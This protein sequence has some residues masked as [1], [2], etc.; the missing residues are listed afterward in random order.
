[1]SVAAER[2][3]QTIVDDIEYPV[4]VVTASAGDDPAGCLVGFTTQCSIDPLRFLVCLSK[5]NHTWEIATRTSRL[6]V[7]LVRPDQRDVAEHF[8]SQSSE[9]RSDEDGVMAIAGRP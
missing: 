6:V 5:Q 9:R 3:F 8:G 2:V 1:M 7:H 4:F